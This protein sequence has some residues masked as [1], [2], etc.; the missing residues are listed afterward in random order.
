MFELHLSLQKFTPFEQFKWAN[1]GSLHDWG[2]SLDWKRLC[3]PIAWASLCLWKPKWRSAYCVLKRGVGLLWQPQDAH[4]QKEGK[5]VKQKRRQNT[6]R[7]QLYFL[8]LWEFKVD[9]CQWAGMKTRE[10]EGVCKHAYVCYWM[11]CNAQVLPSVIT[12][13]W[14][15]QCFS[16]C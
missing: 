10:G 1:W 16:P 5:K 7:A 3:R 9:G 14:Y 11:I 8:F 12:I 6:S 2:L 15:W 4:H 13:V